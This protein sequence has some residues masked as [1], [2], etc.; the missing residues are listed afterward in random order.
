MRNVHSVSVQ[1]GIQ[2]LRKVCT[3]VVC[4]LIMDFERLAGQFWFGVGSGGR[5]GVYPSGGFPVDM[6][7]DDR[8]LMYKCSGSSKTSDETGD[9][10]PDCQ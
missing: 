7:Y 5:F 1:L 3:L 2:V 10:F 4:M 6:S 8:S 9:L